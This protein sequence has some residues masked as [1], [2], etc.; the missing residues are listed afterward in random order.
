LTRSSYAF[1]PAWAAYIANNIIK[2]RVT[3]GKGKYALKMPTLTFLDDPQEASIG[4]TVKEILSVFGIV[5]VVVV[6]V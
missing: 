3:L 2:L 4:I 1:P 6:V 5:I